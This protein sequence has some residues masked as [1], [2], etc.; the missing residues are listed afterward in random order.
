MSDGNDGD[1]C[2]KRCPRCGSTL[3]RNPKG[4]E[5]CSFVG[6]GSERPCTYG[7]DDKGDSDRRIEELKPACDQATNDFYARMGGGEHE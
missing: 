2:D 1:F 5:W 3:L 7:L 4:K 6:G